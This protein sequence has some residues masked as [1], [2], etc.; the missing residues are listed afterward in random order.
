MPVEVE[1]RLPCA[2][3]G[4]DDDPVVAQALVAG[5]LGDELEHALCLVR[6]ELGD[7]VEALDVAFWNDKEVRLGLRVQVANRDEA[8]GGGH[9]VAVAVEAAEEAVVGHQAA[10]IPSSVTAAA[11]TRT[12][13]PT[14]AST[15]QGE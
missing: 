11:R 9:V 13:S 4:V 3:A 2:D 8:V 14:G 10:R 6:R 7:V 5:G 12:S 1:D 15:S